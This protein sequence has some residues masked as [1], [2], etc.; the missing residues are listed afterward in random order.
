MK[1]RDLLL[2]ALVRYGIYWFYKKRSVPVVS[3]QS[4]VAEDTSFVM[5]TVADADVNVK[6][7]ITG[8]KKFGNVPN[9]I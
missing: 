6:Y 7:T 1:N 9:T 3:N 8:F 4:T 5:P 2:L